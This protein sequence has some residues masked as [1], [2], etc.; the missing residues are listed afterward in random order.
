[1]VGGTAQLP[2]SRTRHFGDLLAQQVGMLVGAGSANAGLVVQLPIR[3]DIEP[4][5]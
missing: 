4:I 1:M 2:G 3:Q 5:A